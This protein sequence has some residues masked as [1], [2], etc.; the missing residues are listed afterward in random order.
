L[1]RVF[2]HI[3]ALKAVHTNYAPLNS[4]LNQKPWCLYSH[5][6]QFDFNRAEHFCE[7]R[8]TIV[9]TYAHPTTDIHGG[10]EMRTRR[11]TTITWGLIVLAAVFFAGNGVSFANSAAYCDSYARSTADR[12]SNA[13]GNVLGGAV[14]GAASGALLGGII[15]GGSGAGRGAAIGAGVGALGGT[16]QAAND[17]SSIYN[18]EYYRC[19]NE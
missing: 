5:S 19:M 8:S 10:S 4:D 7:I 17:W 11:N 16:A 15:G 14:G 1:S 18:R 6:G 12:Y 3:P 9:D 13:G 2:S